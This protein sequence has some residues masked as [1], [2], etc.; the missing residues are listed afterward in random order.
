MTLPVEHLSLLRPLHDLAKQFLIH[1]EKNSAALL[2][3]AEDGWGRKS[4]AMQEPGSYFSLGMGLIWVISIL[5]AP[6]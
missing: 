1:G 3:V 6:A 2:A 4:Q 5:E